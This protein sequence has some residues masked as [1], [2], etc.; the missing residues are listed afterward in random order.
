MDINV[1]TVRYIANLAKL[2]FTEEEA[3]KLAKE[4]EGILTHFESIDKFDLSDIK[5]DIFSDDLKPILRKDEVSYFED[6]KKLFSNAKSMKDSAIMVPKI[7][8]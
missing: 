7:I 6:K 5:V 3:L 2:E 1:D 4:F 8:E